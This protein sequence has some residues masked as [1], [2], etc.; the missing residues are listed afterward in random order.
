MYKL[1]SP[2]QYFPISIGNYKLKFNKYSNE[3]VLFEKNHSWMGYNQNTN[4]QSSEFYIEL[5]RAHGICVTT[6]LGLGIIQTHLCLKESV[7]KVIVYEKSNDV[8][9][10]FHRIVKFN[11]F[12]ISK[13]EIKNENANDMKDEI[14]DCLF[15]D[16]FD[17]EP[18][19]YIIDIVRNL[20]YNNQSS[21]VW[22][23]PAGY[24]FLK[25][26]L[27]N[28][29]DISKNG[30][31]LW[32]NYTGIKNLPETL[33]ENSFSYL[34][35]LKRI[36]QQDTSPTNILKKNLDDAELRNKLLNLSKKIKFKN[37]KIL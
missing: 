20:S 23:W 32:K 2:L 15:P 6:G 31:N 34:K 27:R 1:K 28:G 11:N 12:N 21:C 30:Y 13:I 9:E 17:N 3:F 7:T 36:Y 16:H 24:H 29:L 18:D 14:C 33:N 19:D 10:I 5:D 35:E 25:F 37:T 8:I 4:W 26:V 22:Y